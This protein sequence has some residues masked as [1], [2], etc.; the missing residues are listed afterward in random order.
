[1]QVSG[2]IGVTLLHHCDVFV[3]PSSQGSISKRESKPV[4]HESGS[5]FS[6]LITKRTPN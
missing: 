3:D 6:E 1:M 5:D 4:K 2:L